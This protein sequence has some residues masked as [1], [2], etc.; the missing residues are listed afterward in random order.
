MSALAPTGAV[1]LEELLLPIFSPYRAV[2]RTP[3]ACG[4]F[5]ASLAGRLCYGIVS[6]S[7]ILTLTAGNRNYGLAGL[8]MA[9]F[10]LAIVLV[11]PFRA[12]LV[13]RHGP[14]RAL[15]PMAAAFAAVL[16][17]IA[18]I[19]PGSG[20]DDT[21]ITLLAIA[22]GASAPPLGVV[23]RTLWSILV[24]DRDV[25]QTAYSLDGVVEELLYVAGPLIAGVITVTAT[26]AAGLFVTAG[27]MVAGTG[28]FLRS[29]ALSSW[30]V[31]AAEEPSGALTKAPGQAGTGRAILALAFA[32]GAIGLSLGGFG[33][34]IVA[35][36]Q[37]RH[38]PAAVA[39]IEAALSVGSAL[40]GLAY[41]A[42]TWRI[43]AQRRL[44]LLAAGLAVILIPAALSPNLL[45]LALL[46]G[47]AGLLVSPALA[48]AYILADNLA[49]AAAANRAG[50]W[51]NSGYNAG[52]SAGSALSGEMVGR[53]PLSACLPLLAVPSM[54]AI[55]PLLRA[56]LT[57]AAEQQPASGG[58]AGDSVPPE[59][60]RVNSDR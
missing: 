47:L 17:A 11:S 28:L 29:S 44:A 6:L 9:L 25:L 30:P 53:I 42:I 33:L 15:P 26:P 43:P 19:P 21:A 7:L 23:M 14:R 60:E 38:D 34:V 13:D 5:A 20:V 57:P 40:G 36:A 2:L 50:N 54:L 8:V 32:T 24:S 22:A 31:P 35:F 10:G 18:L 37:A 39:W 52:T 48:T 1:S 12:W 3:H 56:R 49:T 41:G 27:L 55:V 59:T 45:V 46:T 58:P 16:V 4:A 51:V